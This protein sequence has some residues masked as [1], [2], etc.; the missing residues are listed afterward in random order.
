MRLR[1]ACPFLARQASILLKSQEHTP[2]PRRKRRGSTPLERGI[3]INR[4]C[5]PPGRAPQADDAAIS[6]RLLIQPRKVY[7]STKSLV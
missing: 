6:I 4:H 2:S 5:D 3:M 1:C 7:H